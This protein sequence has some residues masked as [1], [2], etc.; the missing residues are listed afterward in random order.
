MLP[1]NK[2]YSPKQIFTSALGEVS[3]FIF[4]NLFIFI[5]C[6]ALYNAQTMSFI[7]NP[8]SI[9]VLNLLGPVV[10]IILILLQ[11]SFFKY[12][13]KRNFRHNVSLWRIRRQISQF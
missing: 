3:I 2:L 9:C 10:I 13:K 8:I 5:T 12:I 6:L 7:E 11:I 1:N 4:F